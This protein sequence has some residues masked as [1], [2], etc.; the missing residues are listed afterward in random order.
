MTEPELTETIDVTITI[1]PG[2]SEPLGVAQFILLPYR[3]PRI[4]I[5]TRI[6]PPS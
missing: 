6:P 5:R 2:P 3:Q 1:T 4:F